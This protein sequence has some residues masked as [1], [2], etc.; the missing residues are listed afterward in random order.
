M[1]DLVL[2]GGTVVD[3]VDG[4]YP[5]DVAVRGGRV[6]AILEPGASADAKGKVSAKG[7]HIFPGCVEPHT[8]IGY[9]RN[10][11]DDVESET[12]SAAIGG[13][14]TVMSFHRHY[15]SA[16]PKPYA[17]DLPGLIETIN[18][19][20]HVDMALHFG[21]L[22]EDQ[23]LELEKYIAAGVS[24]FKFYMAYRGADGKTTG[25]INE[26]D[27]GI[28]FEGF[29]TIGRFPHARACVHCENTEIIGRYTK[30]IKAEGRDGLAAWNAARPAFAEA[31]HVR[32]AAFFAEL[33]NCH[34]YYVHI[35]AR[36]GLEEALKHRQRYDKLTIETCI[37]YLTLTKDDE[38][39]GNLAK[40]TPPIRTKSDKERIWEGLMKGEISTVATDHCCVC[41]AQK[42]GDI[43]KAMPGF[44]GMATM[45][46]VMLSEGHH[47]RGMSLQQI[48]QVTAGNAAKAFNVYPQKGTIRVG[49]DADLSI[50]DVNLER[51]VDAKNLG[52]ASDFSLQDGQTLK[53]WPVATYLRGTL[54]ARDGKL[55]A[56]PGQGRFIKR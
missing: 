38:H 39:V 17:E 16:Q 34:L 30:R 23:M 22:I 36:E 40:V 13:V 12:G 3:P 41:R 48:A 8:H 49:A 25:M 11:A 55:V 4:V 46:P 45:L 33:T 50:V 27:D 5:G 32:R 53:G 56:K 35:G 7:K 15:Q 44:P 21:I 47:R 54:V 26:C 6:A 31:E 10:F 1:F 24:S 9:A 2:Q 14:T 28:L 51:V 52:S 20:A 37:H 29:K 42:Q 43:W 19:R 18:S